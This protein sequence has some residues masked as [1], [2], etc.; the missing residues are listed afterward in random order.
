MWKKKRNRIDFE[1][2]SSVLYADRESVAYIYGAD[3]LD[4]WVDY[5]PGIFNIP[6]IIK[7][8]SINT[9]NVLQNNNKREVTALEKEEIIKKV[10]TYYEMQ[11]VKVIID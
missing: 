8:Q 10:V 7:T 3:R 4:V 11:G 2:G 6:R 1:D 9:W 5:G